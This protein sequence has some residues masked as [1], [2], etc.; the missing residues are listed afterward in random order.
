[1]EIILHHNNIKNHNIFFKPPIKNQNEKYNNFYKII[2]SNNKYSLKY[3]LIKLDFK[4][5]SIQQDKYKYKLIINLCDPFIKILENIEYTIL[6]S[7]KNNLVKDKK[8]NNNLSNDI[9]IRGYIYI[10][11]EYPNYENLYLKISGAWEDNKNIGLVYKFYYN[12]ST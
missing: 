10:F 3:I 6:N 2:Y 4:N 8:I 11:N 1:M 9:K 5:Y 7:L 12:T